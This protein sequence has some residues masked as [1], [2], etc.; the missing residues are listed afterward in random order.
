MTQRA[1][2]LRALKTGPVRATAFSLPNVIDDG[3]PIYRVAARVQELRDAGYVIETTRFSV[4]AAV[5]EL[6]SEP[7][8]VRDASDGVGDRDA[9]RRGP[10]DPTGTA[11]SPTSPS[12]AGG[13]QAVRDSQ[14]SRHREP[15]RQDADPF[16]G[17]GGQLL[18]GDLVVDVHTTRPHWMEAT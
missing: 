11:A 2:V 4:G 1:R 18:L 5:Y 3:P 10:T 8:L 9:R 17:P 15:G 6:I 14:V 12:G 13:Q 7:D 16:G